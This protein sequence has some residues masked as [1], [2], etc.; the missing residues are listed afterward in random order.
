MGKYKDILKD[1]NAGTAGV[2]SKIPG[3][4]AGF[5]DLY[6]AAYADGALSA[7]HKELIA[8]GI[9]VREGCDG[10]IASHVR[11]PPRRRRLK[12]ASI[13]PIPSTRVRPGRINV[14]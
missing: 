9:A 3:V 7:K 12:P 10:C 6:R 13:A 14:E 1:L 5:G 11:Q 8:V 4:Y 2:R